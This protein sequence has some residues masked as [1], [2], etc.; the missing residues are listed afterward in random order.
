MLDFIRNCFIVTKIDILLSFLSQNNTA[1]S[2][3][4]KVIPQ[5]Y[6][7]V[8]KTYRKVNRFGLNFEL[9]LSNLVDWAVYFGL[10][11]KAHENLVSLCKE[12][13][14]VFDIGTNI[15]AVLLKIAAKIN[16]N[17]YVYGF[18]PDKYN[19]SRCQTNI[20]LNIL[21]NL[22]LNNIALGDKVSC[23]EIIVID[24]KNRGMNRVVELESI[25]LEKKQIV[26]D[27]FE[28]D[29][30]DNIVLKNNVNKIDV[31]KID[32]EGYEMKVLKGAENSI[33]KYRPKL[34]VEVD[35]NYLKIQGNS[36]LQLIKFIEDL[37]Y[38]ISNLVNNE[39]VSSNMSFNNCHLDIIALS[40]T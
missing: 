14:V 36:A 15:G 11:E 17:G 25:E 24:S 4:F 16:P 20:K 27:S 22:C 7:Y 2:L 6:N 34:V 30:L 19:F 13:S 39:K 38:S 32:V 18:E 31:I 3:I 1:S 35:D 37:D 8:S 33:K 23:G 21:N 9:D 12:D 29:T 40:N 26:A 28:I 10:K 5:H